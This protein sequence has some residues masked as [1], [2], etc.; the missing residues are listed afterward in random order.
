MSDEAT[1]NIA[2]MTDEEKVKR[3]SQAIA[4]F[5]DGRWDEV[6]DLWLNQVKPLLRVEV[7]DEDFIQRF[8]APLSLRLISI[9]IQAGIEGITQA[10]PVF[11]GP[12]R[13]MVAPSGLVSIKLGD[14]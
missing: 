12:F 1:S 13:M 6:D 14:G 7:S 4:G 2:P 11:E 5:I 9:G 8:A 10:A 3:I